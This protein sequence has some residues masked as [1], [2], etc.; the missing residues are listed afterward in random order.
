M[1]DKRQIIPTAAG[2]TYM[3]P[4]VVFLDRYFG[5]V[6]SK[7]GDIFFT[8][9]TEDTPNPE[10][11]VNINGVAWKGTWR[12][13]SD[14]EWNYLLNEREMTYDKPRYSNWHHGVPMS[15]G[16]IY[17]GL[18]VYPD[19]YNGDLVTERRFSWEEVNEAS[20]LFLLVAGIRD[21][22]QVTLLKGA[23]A[24]AHYWCSTSSSKDENNAYLMT[25]EEVG[26]PFGGIV[27]SEDSY[28]GIAHNVR[29]VKDIKE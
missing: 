5:S 16:W 26:T 22:D 17:R 18:F 21:K 6:I 11:S 28:R 9:K 7:V 1:T 27:I 8:N 12:V 14:K 24:E 15:N 20:I 4:E 19:D 13:L 25:F 23:P 10:F 29:L 2:L 3:S